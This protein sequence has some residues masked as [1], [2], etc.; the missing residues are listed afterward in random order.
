MVFPSNIGRLLRDELSACWRFGH[1]WFWRKIVCCRMGRLTDRS[2]LGSWFDFDR[3]GCQTTICVL[4]VNIIWIRLWCA[5]VV[6][7]TCFN[8][9]S[10]QRQ[11]PWGENLSVDE[12]ALRRAE[13]HQLSNRVGF[14][15]LSRH[16][17]NSNFIVATIPMTTNNILLATQE[18]EWPQS[19]IAYCTV[20][21]QRSGCSCCADDEWV[22]YPWSKD[23]PLLHSHSVDLLDESSFISAAGCCCLCDALWSSFLIARMRDGNENTN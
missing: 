14:H 21:G 5:L 19:C 6:Q 15:A 12:L 18:G 7:N 13:G 11:Y 1:V 20:C 9:T 4:K 2:R 23:R 16:C 17:L 22:E 3:F 10:S 8:R